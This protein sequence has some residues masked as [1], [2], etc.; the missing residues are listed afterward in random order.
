MAINTDVMNFLFD[1][2]RFYDKEYNKIADNCFDEVNRALNEIAENNLKAQN[3]TILPFGTFAIK[4]N[5]QVLEPMEFYCI[6]PADRSILDKENQQKSAY[7][8][9]NKSSSS[10]KDIYANVF[11]QS[12]SSQL[13]A[14]DVAEIIMK[15]MQKYVD[16][17]DK[18]Y[19][20][21][22]VVFIKFKLDEE[23]VI[24]VQIYVVY[25][26]SGN[27]I[28]EFS[29]LGYK[30][31]EKSLQ[32][33]KNIQNKN[34]ETNGNYLLMCKLLK[35]LELELILANKSNIY[36]SDK[37]LFV[38]NVLYNVPNVFF[39]SEDFCEMF[40]N[41]VNY[42][43]QC[44]VEHILLPDGTNQQMFLN[45][46]YYASQ[47]YKSFVKKIIYIYQNADV[48]IADALNKQNNAE[49]TDKN[50]AE[51]T[52]NDNKNNSTMQTN[53][54][55]KINKKIDKDNHE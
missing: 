21:N 36:L 39:K 44:D 4:N 15:N 35:M 42:L 53:E 47:F 49:N 51:Q 9:K 7:K 24:T 50:D 26:F 20:K 43:K 40:K 33:L 46:G 48:M 41:I 55:Q 45:N 25:D 12:K 27:G 31:K 38:E 37:T 11:N 52:D 22:N 16:E 13:T 2:M 29:K 34:M 6:L 3:V 54:V 32:L 1:V 8:R 19:F 30:L 17:T 14:I 5:Y 23:T 28:L 18:V 10:I